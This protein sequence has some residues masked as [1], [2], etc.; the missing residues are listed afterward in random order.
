MKYFFALIAVVLSLCFLIGN[1]VSTIKLAD[2]PPQSSQ[3]LSA[4]TT[5]YK[6][7]YDIVEYLYKGHFYIRVGNQHSGLIHA[8]HCP[9]LSTNR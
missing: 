4:E 5:Y 9:C 3:E 1:S 8:Q 2:A 7:G 6:R